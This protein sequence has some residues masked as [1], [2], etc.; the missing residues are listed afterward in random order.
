V[1]CFKVEIDL[2]ILIRD[3]RKRQL[4]E[5]LHSWYSLHGY[6][7]WYYTSLMPSQCKEIK[8]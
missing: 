4:Y 3:D 5:K 6:E 7:V 8:D 1:E 2:L